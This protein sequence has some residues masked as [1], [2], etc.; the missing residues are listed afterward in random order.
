VA[1]LSST[2]TLDE[3][4][5]AY[6]DNSSYHEDASTAKAAAFITACRF[7]L[8]RTAKRA[9]DGRS[10]RE[11]EHETRLL[12]EEMEAADRWLARQSGSGGTGQTRYFGST[13]DFRD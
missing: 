13:H 4:N 9:V 5:A 2:S 1:T 11:L 8:R 12:R 10:G 7:L 6:D 3:I